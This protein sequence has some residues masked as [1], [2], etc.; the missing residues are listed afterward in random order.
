MKTGKALTLMFARI[1]K[2]PAFF[3]LWAAS[4]VSLIGDWL[5]FVAISRLVLERGGNAFDLAIVFAVHALPHAGLTPLAGF[6][7]D[8]LD[9]RKLLVGIP[10]IQAALTTLM[11]FAALSGAIALVQGLVLVRSAFTSFM[12]PAESAAIRHTVPPD[13]LTWANAVLSGTWSVTFVVGMALGGLIAGLGAGPALGMDAASFVLGALLAMGLPK[14]VPERAD[15]KKTTGLVPM[16]RSLPHDFRAA[17]TAARA[18]KH[19]FQAVFSKA[20]VA[21]AGGAG[22]LVLNLVSDHV[23]PFGTAA[24]SL[25]LLQAVRGSGTGAGPLC[26]AALSRGRFSRDTG[27]F[28]H[29]SAF[30]TFAG[31]AAF[32]LLQSSPV[33]L[34]GI[35]FVWGFGG[36][37]NWVLAS[38]AL[39]RLAPDAMVGRLSSLD[40]LAQTSCM[41]FGAIFASLLLDRGSSMSSVAAGF[42][43]VGLIGW[44]ALGRRTFSGATTAKIG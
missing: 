16:L 1:A 9:R 3:R 42:V 17:F 10:L 7:A 2:R 37:G 21:L 19:L 34:L 11:V 39:Q 44:I 26:F 38:S 23:K 27:W 12:V 29:I 4:T 13:E 14:M 32:P 5:G 40:D 15:A 43:I 25:G 18:D 30:L 35:V 36:G 22:W 31:I 41:V 28:E 8:R 20:P 24:L 33:A 6:L